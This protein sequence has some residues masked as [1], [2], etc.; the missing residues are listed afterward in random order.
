[1]PPHPTSDE[2][3]AFLLGKLPLEQCDEVASHIEACPPC[4]ETL[5][6]L[7]SQS[8]TLLESVRKR[9]EAQPIDAACQRA[10]QQAMSLVNGNP[11]EPS[12]T[13]SLAKLAGEHETTGAG[14][15]SP[16]VAPEPAEVSSPNFAAMAQPDAPRLVSTA[17]MVALLRTA[18]ILGDDDWASIQA[19]IA[20][21][22]D[23]V[24]LLKRLFE[25]GLL[26]KFQAKQLY[27][28]QVRGLSFGEYIVLDRI[29]AGGMGQVFKARHR[30]MDR[31]VAIKVMAS[32]A[33]KDQ[34][35]VKRFQREVKAA[36]RL[37]HPHIVTAY[38]AGEYNG[39][40]FLVMELVDGHDLSGYIKQHGPL[41]VADAIGALLQAA[42]GLAFAH[43][44]G[45]VHRDIKPA[46]L[47]RDKKGVVRILDMGLARFEDPLGRGQDDGLTQSGAVMGTV[48]YM[49]P[50][51][52]FNTRD[53]GPAADV[54]S[55]GCTLYRL[56]TGQALYSGETVVQKILAHREQP[57]PTLVSA[58]HTIPPALTKLYERMVAKKME[59]R[60]TMAEVVRELESLHKAAALEHATER[61]AS[62][63]SD[64]SHNAVTV[65][66]G[67][68]RGR[69]P[70]LKYL[71]AAAGAAALLFFG[72]WIIVR[73]KDGKEIAR[74]EGP[75]GSTVSIQTTPPTT[76]QGATSLPQAVVPTAR[77]GNFKPPVVP[78]TSAKLT[79]YEILTS[80]DYEWTQAEN[81]GPAVNSGQPEGF[82]ALSAD[83]LRLI[84]HSFGRGRGSLCEATRSS[85]AESF[86]LGEP[87][88]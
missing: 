51:Q 75:E 47:L 32:A 9:G 56:L 53:A 57:I 60:P 68:N 5:G 79:P 26:T 35:A 4:Q 18:N 85:V 49:A 62:Q 55:L 80:P 40:H 23:G 71:A 61:S 43:A 73:D 63:H 41:A 3:S 39:V 27:E 46:N 42:R 78:A 83:G 70:P 31:L 48:D 37:T 65:G 77:L 13:A 15:R 21:S 7:E 33:M 36:A 44:E 20:A 29:G 72:V 30:R 84:Y 74:V 64:T 88:G 87:L 69:R 8:D 54:Y 82:P 12:I 6:R 50:E 66:R 1:M 81:L 28:G 86:G 45:V 17:D 10:M 34:E 16:T 52:A 19:D 2:L 24:T 76:P 22:A 14:P 59:D 67:S 25:R 38:D 58:G 11:A